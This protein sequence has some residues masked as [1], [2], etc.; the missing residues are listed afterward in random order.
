MFRD[1]VY[2]LWIFFAFMW[3][4]ILKTRTPFCP[5]L[6]IHA[7]HE[8]SSTKLSLAVFKASPGNLFAGKAFSAAL[9]S[10]SSICLC[11]SLIRLGSSTKC[12]PDSSPKCSLA[13]ATAQN[14]NRMSVSCHHYLITTLAHNTRDVRV[15]W[16]CTGRRDGGLKSLATIRDWHLK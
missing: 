15:A 7:V 3:I 1:Q 6:L 16:L 10:V 5:C 8:F 9:F 11:H 13:Y 12:R 14:L 4:V 2:L